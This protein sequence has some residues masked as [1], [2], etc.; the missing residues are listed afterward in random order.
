MKQKNVSQQV[1]EDKGSLYWLM[2]SKLD[3][4]AK[5]SR[6]M[7]DTAGSLVTVWGRA[8]REDVKPQQFLGAGHV[9]CGQALEF[10]LVLHG[11]SH[12]LTSLIKTCHHAQFTDENTEATEGQQCLHSH[13]AVNGRAEA[14]PGLWLLNLGSSFLLTWF[15]CSCLFAFPGWLSSCTSCHGGSEPRWGGGHL[16]LDTWE[17]P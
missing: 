1:E 4:K 16:Y 13:E 15:L 12:E 14:G 17:R 10:G 11:S 8:I 5:D 3:Y 2:C 9:H 7:M 6:V